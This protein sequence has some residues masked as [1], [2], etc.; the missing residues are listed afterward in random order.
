MMKKVFLLMILFVLFGCSPKSELIG[1]YYDSRDLPAFTF[2]PDNKVV[3][4]G[5]SKADIP[6]SRNGDVIT[7]TSQELLAPIEITVNS[8]GTLGSQNQIFVKK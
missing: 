5:V 6:Y 7:I 2:K 3:L 4:I 8:N 1:D